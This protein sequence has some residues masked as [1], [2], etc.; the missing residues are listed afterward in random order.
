MPARRGGKVWSAD[1]GWIKKQ[2]TEERNYS[3]YCNESWA[4]LISFF[5][6][7]PDVMQDVFRSE[8]AKTS[9]LDL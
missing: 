8:N 1:I 3:E 9:V 2:E 4:L 6:W 7:Y 5:R